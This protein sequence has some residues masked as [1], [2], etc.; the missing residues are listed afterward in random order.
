LSA[1]FV[2][3]AMKH[4]F[5][6]KMID[7]LGALIEERHVSNAAHRVGINQP[8]MSLALK[9]LREI[10]NDPIVVKTDNGYVATETAI[11]VFEELRR[12]RNVINRAIQNRQVFNAGDAELD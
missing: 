7:Y 6:I 1:A 9:R 5:S 3:A 2:I 4:D 10:L 12:A 11:E 8:A